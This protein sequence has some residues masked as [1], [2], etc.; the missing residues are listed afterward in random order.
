M[1]ALLHPRPAM[2]RG[3]LSNPILIA[4]RKKRKRIFTGSK[5][6]WLAEA[7]RIGKA[8]MFLDRKRPVPHVQDDVLLL[9]MAAY[10]KGQIRR[11]RQNLRILA[12][13]A[14]T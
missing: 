4:C 9:H 3:L 12:V 6:F 13:V 7:F 5:A 2:S 10:R 1:R 11:G 8:R 14:A